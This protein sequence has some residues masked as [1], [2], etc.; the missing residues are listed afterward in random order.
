M[1]SFMMAI[2]HLMTSQIG[3][4]PQKC[5]KKTKKSLDRRSKTKR[6]G[7]VMQGYVVKDPLAFSSFEQKDAKRVNNIQ[8]NDAM[9]IYDVT[10]HLM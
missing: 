4:L 9:Q 5:K 6:F 7:P 1:I 2:T 8:C 10:G 3:S